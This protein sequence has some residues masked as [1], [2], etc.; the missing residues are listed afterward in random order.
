M[1]E[2]ETIM[3]NDNIAGGESEP[4]ISV[5]TV[6]LNA[7]QRLEAAIRSLLGQNYRNYEHIV[8]DGGSTDDTLEILERY[9]DGITTLISE[10]DGGIYDA[11][12]KGIQ[13]ASGH[14]LY[15]LNA[16]DAL[17]DDNVF[18][19]VI[20]AFGRFP[21]ADVLYGD[22]QLLYPDGRR[23]LATYPKVL[24]WRH[25]RDRTLCHQSVFT[26][27]SAFAR[28]GLFETSYRLAADFAWILKSIWEHDLNYQYQPQTFCTFYMGGGHSAADMQFR[29][30]RERETAIKQYVAGRF[31]FVGSYQRNSSRW[32]Q[33]ALSRISDL[34]Q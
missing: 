1:P 25:F 32:H 24:T 8:I 30:K 5:V 2:I 15:F 12:N 22:A 10:P 16:D 11:M 26:K 4:R 34:L 3:N 9:R 13:L 20:A 18:V 14:I 21:Q 19:D 6:C 17:Y 7:Q 27:R 33:R 23:K 28:V 31:D 29:L